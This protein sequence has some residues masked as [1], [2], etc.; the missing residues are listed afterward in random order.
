MSATL[1]EK[2]K[3]S[4]RWF[5][6][7]VHNGVR[8]TAKAND[9]Q[10]A[11]STAREIN[12]R[13]L[14][15]TF[16]LKEREGVKDFNH[17]AD[18]YLAH[19]TIKP[20]TLTDYT[21]ILANHVRPKFGKKD[22][23]TITRLEVKNYLKKQLSTLKASTVNHH[24]AVIANVF[25]MALDDAVIDQNPAARIG[26]ITATSQAKHKTEIA[27]FLTRDQLADILAAFLR[28]RPE[29][30]ALVIVLART[31]MRV[32]EAVA[33]KWTDIDYSQKTITV[34]RAKA[35]TIIDTPKSGKTRK[36]DMS[37]QLASV[38]HDKQA[39]SDNEW[40]FP[41]KHAETIDP[42]SWRKNV[43]M[44]MVDIAGITGNVRVHDLRHTYASLMIAQ[45]QPL[46]YIQRQLGHHSI[47][48]TA[49]FYS[50]LLPTDD[51]KAVNALD[52]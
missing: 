48:V 19:A 28:Y 52:D 17:Y 43:F 36:I 20:S 12:R 37:E 39:H 24:R 34:S 9:K 42:T 29:H 32:G 23:S 44:P 5:V 3:G 7:V 46:I 18:M 49:D 14:E 8:R 21:Y 15:G 47:S 4:G 50:H 27:R 6:V 35:R 41:G 22:I 25:E 31:G 2:P 10:Q 11:Q 51:R 40:V 38:L 33:L 1:R 13:I 26:R 45:G 16:E 30:Y